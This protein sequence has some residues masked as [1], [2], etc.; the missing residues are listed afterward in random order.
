MDC[1]KYRES[2]GDFIK[3]Y[4]VSMYKFIWRA[5]QTRRGRGG[6]TLLLSFTLACSDKPQLYFRIIFGHRSDVIIVPSA[7]LH[8]CLNPVLFGVLRGS[9]A[10]L[11][12]PKAAPPAATTTGKCQ[13]RWLLTSWHIKSVSVLLLSIDRARIHAFQGISSSSALLEL[14]FFPIYVYL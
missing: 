8:I 9:A 2:I 12:M 1:K 11:P 13:L 3:V 5:A 6:A 10:V 14:R 4:K 7:A